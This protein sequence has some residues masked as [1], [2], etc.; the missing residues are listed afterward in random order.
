MDRPAEPMAITLQHLAEVFA[1]FK[2]GFGELSR[3][4]QLLL[5]QGVGW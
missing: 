2:C 1:H 4:S 5:V 3:S